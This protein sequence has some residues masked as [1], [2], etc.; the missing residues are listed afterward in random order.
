VKLSCPVEAGASIVV[1]S[2]SG[3]S[4]PSDMCDEE[5]TRNILSKPYVIRVQRACSSSY[6]GIHRQE[7]GEW[8]LI[9]F[10]VN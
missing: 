1:D 7:G 4:F 2:V 3:R 6:H 9:N 5:A 10:K 8:D